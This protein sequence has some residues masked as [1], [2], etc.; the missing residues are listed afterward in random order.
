MTS[1]SR[2][3]SETLLRAKQQTTAKLRSEASSQATKLR[4]QKPALT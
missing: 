4:L 2:D 1:Q 3:F